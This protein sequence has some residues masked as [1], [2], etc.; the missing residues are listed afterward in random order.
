MKNKSVFIIKTFC[1]IIFFI[2][3]FNPLKSY[4]FFY[5]RVVK[6]GTPSAYK[7]TLKDLY[8]FS[9]KE[10]VWDLA[11]KKPIVLDITEKDITNSIVHKISSG[12]YSKIKYSA[13]A[14]LIM[15]GYIKY[16]GLVYYT[17]PD[18]KNGTAVTDNFDVDNPPKD[19]E[20]SELTVFG[21]NE[22]EYLSPRIENINFS[23]EESKIKGVKITVNLT[24]SLTLYQTRADPD[25][26]QLMPGQPEIILFLE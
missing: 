14:T 20:E 24:D 13:N 3:L 21:Y 22:W 10:E 6:T 2:G 4:S 18:S 23:V 7:I 16:K 11:Q 1:F 5:G 9:D 8:V 15:K 17:S 19:Y 26:Y 25:I 12:S